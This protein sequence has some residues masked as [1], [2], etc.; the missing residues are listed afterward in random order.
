MKN[1]HMYAHTGLSTQASTRVCICLHM[2]FCH[3]P[4]HW[5]VKILGLEGSRWSSKPRLS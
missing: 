4:A 3:E 2:N 1:T 5:V